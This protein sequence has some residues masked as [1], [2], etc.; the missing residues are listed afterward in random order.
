M[1]EEIKAAVQRGESFAFETTLAGQGYLRHIEQWRSQGY[2]VSLYFLSLPN[3]K[4]AIERVA[5]R[6]RQGGHEIAEPIIRRRF[7]A[8]W[9]N[10]Q[11]HYRAVVDDWAVYDNAGS[12][13][14]LLDW[15]E[16]P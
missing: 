10:F 2:R 1:L 8:G 6:V 16:N 11:Q 4:I 12:M 14:K 15:G 5:Q 13:P 7:A 9:R 3:A